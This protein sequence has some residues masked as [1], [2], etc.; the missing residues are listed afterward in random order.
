LCLAVHFLL[1]RVQFAQKAAGEVQSVAWKAFWQVFEDAC[2]LSRSERSNVQHVGEFGFYFA[3]DLL[4]LAVGSCAEDYS[5]YWLLTFWVPV[6]IPSRLLQ[7]SY[8][9]TQD[10]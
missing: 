3:K 8:G 5:S 10:A 9:R 2:V 6:K 7:G 1:D 4:D